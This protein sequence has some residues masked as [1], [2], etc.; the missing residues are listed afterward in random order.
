MFKQSQICMDWH[1]T[2]IFH[3]YEKIVRR[4]VLLS[5]P[6]FSEDLI[7]HTDASKMN[8]GGLIIQNGKLVDFYSQN[9]T[10]AQIIYTTT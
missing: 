5:Y 6:N 2:E 10:P 1:I 3:G 9:L 8:L 7:I 4:Y